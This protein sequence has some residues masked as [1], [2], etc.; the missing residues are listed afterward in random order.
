LQAYQMVA[1]E[2]DIQ[3][4]VITTSNNFADI[5]GQPSFEAAKAGVAAVHPDDRTAHEAKL[6]HAIVTQS[7]YHSEYRIVRADNEQTRWI[8]E[9]G[10]PVA[11]AEDVVDKLFG[12][13]I[14]ITERHRFEEALRES[15]ARFRTM[16][17]NAPVKIWMTDAEGRCIY[18]NQK[19]YAFTGQTPETGLGSGWLDAVHPDDVE[20]AAQNCLLG[21]QTHQPFQ[22][23][24]RFRRHDG[25]YRWTIDSASPRFDHNGEYLGCIGSVLDITERKE[26]EDRLQ[27][28][29]QLGEAV[30]RAEAVEQIYELA[31]FGLERILHVDR[32]SVLLFDTEGVMR[33]HAWRGLSDAYRQGVDGHSPWS[34]D[35][36]DPLPILIPD[37]AYQADLGPLQQIISEEG[38]Q[39]LAFIPLVE[40]GK[41]L[42]KFML[43]YNQPHIFSEAEVQW[44]Q[45]IARHV[46][47]ALQR[48]QV[49]EK[50]RQSNETLEQRVE[51]RTAELQHS[52]RELDQ[53][54]YISSHDLKAPLRGINLLATWIEQDA[55]DVLPQSSKEHLRKLQ[56]RIQRMETLLTD[57]LAYSRAAR[58][59]HPAEEVEIKELIRNV[60]EVLAPPPGF[61]VNVIGEVTVVRVERIPLETVIRNL[62]GNAIKHHDRPREG[63]VNITFHTQK[64]WIEFTISDNG[65]GIDPSFH[66]RIFEM[67][68]TLL[69][70]D[71]IEGSGV[72]LAIVKK[73]VE[74][75]GG[76]LGIESS[77]GTGAAFRFTW[78]S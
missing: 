33:F 54:A 43:Y 6:Q 47:H 41:I 36:L 37:I 51:E 4:N 74:S 73:L 61:G 32:A 27:V 50:L 49:E 55:A 40:Q 26:A 64:E 52:N 68:Q 7:E 72:G 21:V 29:Y 60:V 11:N 13:A 16:A 5:Y 65:P 66:Q 31:L 8:E 10:I 42:G 38:I 45:T 67:F 56:G 71:Q 22:S 9:R 3:S 18:L 2:W 77:L 78:P 24:Y 35:D 62:I 15:E 39:S 1:W 12:V 23:E 25:V 30:N 19:W 69:P 20:A 34:V 28:L 63:E 59:R 44:A 75:R 53:F 17:D 57:L 14:D 46:A 48:K 70:R 76:T 58:Q